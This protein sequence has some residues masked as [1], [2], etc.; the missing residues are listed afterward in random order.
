MPFRAIAGHQ[1]VRRLLARAIDRGALPPSV[2]F[3]GPAGVG[4][5]LTAVALAQ[6]LNCAAPIGPPAHAGG[7][8]FGPAATDSAADG[9]DACGQCA[10]CR[11]IQQRQHPDV[12]VVDGGAN[13]EEMRGVLQS[14]AYRPFEGRRRVFILDAV[15]TLSATV[16]NALLKTLEEPMPS[17]QFVLVSAR[18]DMLLDTVRS[19]CP[20]LRFGRLPVEAVAQLLVDQHGFEAHAARDAAFASDGSPGRA[21]VE[22][23]EQGGLIRQLAT[24]VIAGV[25]TASPVQ[26]LRMA[27]LLLEPGET[28]S[29][30]A[31]ATRFSSERDQ[32]NE[33]LEAVAGMLRDLGAMAAGAD[34]RWLSRDPSPDLA[35][36]G[37]RLGAARLARAFDAVERARA[38]L[39][40]NASSKVVAD[41]IVQQM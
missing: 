2:I 11:R 16:Q 25:A 19:R 4:K 31:R 23:S 12:V 39:D 34:A 24:Q 35:A 26:R 29:R 7:P 17:S 21:L 3:A 41:W 38:A 5:C 1:R 36:L 8:G 27:A 22:M 20:L 30:R 18:P 10:P 40:R 32:L 13:I 6:R 9:Q 14:A 28:R 37:G 33:R 15:D